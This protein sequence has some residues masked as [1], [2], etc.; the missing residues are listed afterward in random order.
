MN[1]CIHLLAIIFALALL[2]MV[3]SIA[4]AQSCSTP[5]TLL[6]TPPA[7]IKIDP[8]LPNGSILWSGNI[9]TAQGV[10]GSCGGGTFKMDWAGYGPDLGNNL[11]ATT[12]PGIAMK[13]GFAAGYTGCH[14]GQF[15][16][17]SCSG[18]YAGGAPGAFVLQMQFVKTGPIV[19]GGT[20]TGIFAQA[21]RVQA[22]AIFY[23]MTWGG[24]VV[25]EPNIPTCTV[26]TPSISVPLGSPKLSDFTQVGYT[27]HSEPFNISLTCAGGDDG[28]VTD[29][30]ITLTDQTNPA[31]ISDTLT[32]TPD[33]TANG[34][35]IQVLNGSTVVSYGPDSSV[36]G[37][38]NQWQAGSTGNGTFTI[39]LTARYI[40]IAPAVTPG[41]ANGRATFTMSYP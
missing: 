1:K 5:W 15:F 29:V 31:N 11:Y 37:N 27:S 6:A 28:K 3:P 7:T 30:Y 36:V 39:P 32:L 12:L 41:R 10:G 26:A 22:N 14:S 2:S 17:V 18:N 4:K 16:P 9:Q 40:Q 33:S 38:T 13:V 19:G 21:M 34:V 24:P 25:I 20:L 8:S 35:G 23:N